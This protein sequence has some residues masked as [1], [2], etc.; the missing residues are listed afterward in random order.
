MDREI[1]YGPF[2][3]EYDEEEDA[4]TFSVEGEVSGSQMLQPDDWNV[5]T[6]L[7]SSMSTPPSA[8][9]SRS[10]PR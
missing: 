10:S 8:T 9:P 5:G 3:L 6:H 4:W 2:S 7:G 1:S